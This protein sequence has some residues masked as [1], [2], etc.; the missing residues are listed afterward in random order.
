MLKRISHISLSLLL[1][2][3]TIGFAVSKHYCGDSLVDVALNKNADSCCDDGA[4]CHNETLIY[5][6]DEDFSAPQIA[7][8][9][10]LQEIAV[11]G[12]TLFITN[13]IPDEN[14]SESSFHTNS[15]LHKKVDEFLSLK[16]VF[17]L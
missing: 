8:A 9:P 3:S 2:I 4:C 5:Q 11:L 15:L 13:Q 6:L 12:F 1:L 16:Q 7:C 17:L 10:D 14:Y